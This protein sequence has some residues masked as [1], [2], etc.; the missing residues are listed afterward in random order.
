MKPEYMKDLKVV[1]IHELVSDI[2]K[3][4]STRYEIR[5]QYGQTILSDDIPREMKEY[6]AKTINNA[7]LPQKTKTILVQF[8]LEGKTVTRK[9]SKNVLQNPDGTFALKHTKVFYR[10]LAY[11]KRKRKEYFGTWAKR[12]ITYP[13]NVEMVFYLPLYDK[14]IYM[15]EM[16]EATLICLKEIGVLGSISSSTVQSINGTRIVRTKENK[17]ATIITVS[18]IT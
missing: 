12:N 17:Y 15:H 4:Y 16:V 3:K 11:H 8:K 13:V 2:T 5:N 14:D 9:D 1:P 7:D 6:I 10:W 18:K